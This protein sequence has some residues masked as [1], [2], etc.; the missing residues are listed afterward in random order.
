MI[1]TARFQSK[2]TSKRIS[3]LERY[4]FFYVY[5][6]T[7]VQDCTI[8][9]TIDLVYVLLLPE[10]IYENLTQS[11]IIIFLELSTHDDI[12][13]SLIFSSYYFPSLFICNL[14]SRYFLVSHLPLYPCP[15]I[16]SFGV[17]YLSPSYLLRRLVALVTL[18]L[19]LIRLSWKVFFL[20]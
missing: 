7:L 14:I 16:Y 19:I 2:G 15:F 3:A 9:V 20:K 6:S 11:T 12:L 4:L 1:R 5:Y 8:K 10:S 13:I 17:S 18:S